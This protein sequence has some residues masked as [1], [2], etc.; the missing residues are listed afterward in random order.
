MRREGHRVPTMSCG[1]RRARAIFL[2][3]LRSLNALHER[4]QFYNELTSNCTTNVRVH[5]AATAV[6]KPPPWDWRILINGYADQ[7]L[8]ERGDLIRD[9][10]AFADLKKQALINEK[11]KAAD[12]D[13]DF[14][15]RIRDGVIGF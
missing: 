9:Q 13:A 12:R 4:P 5:T 3:Y 7:M 15:R 1:V 14:S 10:L 8:Y 11:A 6:G 2:D